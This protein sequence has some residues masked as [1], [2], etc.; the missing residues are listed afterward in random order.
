MIYDYEPKAKDD[1]VLHA[2]VAYVE[3]VVSNLTPSATVIMETFP[4][5]MSTYAA[6]AS[7]Y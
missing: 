5:R 6:M 3:L 2:V 1:R 4:F 7:S